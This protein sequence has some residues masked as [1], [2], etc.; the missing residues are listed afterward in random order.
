[1]RILHILDHS[2]PVQSGYAFRSAAIIREQQ[3]LG[4]KCFVV[5][6][7]KHG[8]TPVPMETVDGVTVYRT[9]AE[10]AWWGRGPILGQLEVIRSLRT[11]IL[12]VIAIAKPDILHAHSPCLNGLAG[13]GLALPLVYEL[14]SSW[15]DAAVSSGT[16]TEGSL[17]Y[18]ASRWLESTV[19][20]AADAVTVICDGLREEVVRRGVPAGR[21]TV[22]PNAVD[23]EMFAPRSG[24]QSPMRARF[25]LTG[26][27]VV[28]FVGSFFAWEGLDVLISA[29]PALLHERSDVRVMLVGSGPHEP[30][31]RERVSQLGLSER[32]VF[33][34]QA[35]HDAV[36]D[37]YDAID[38][39][40][41]PRTPMRL[42]NM[43]TPL[44]PLEAMALG[45]VFVASDVGGHRE[46]VRDGINGLLFRAGDSSALA[47][48]IAKISGEPSLAERLRAGG[49]DFVH[50]E[51]LWRHV[52]PRYSAVYEAVQSHSRA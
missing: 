39:L 37:Y 31:L 16:T 18:R 4:L 30:A 22:V 7:A 48:I 32:V 34:G 15:E 44:K 14:R 11:R 12:E 45:K 3:R 26:F 43:V 35:P 28:G 51:R 13:L 9:A 19:L 33:T 41:Y 1:M 40:V 36:L 52:V 24:D 6:G 5:T 23:T 46:L 10:P 20:R 27:Y 21:V 42:T 17:R 29:M 2:L 25:G 50:R 8:R 49:L 47:Q 38:L